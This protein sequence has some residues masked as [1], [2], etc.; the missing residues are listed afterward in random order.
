MAAPPRNRITLPDPLRWVIG[1][2]AALAV[3]ATGYVIG[4]AT[5]IPFSTAWWKDFARPLATVGAGVFAGDPL[6]VH[7]VGLA[8]RDEPHVECCGRL[9]LRPTGSIEDGA[10]PRGAADWSVINMPGHTDDA[11]RRRTACS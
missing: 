10:P 11:N 6:G 7:H 5:E 8:I 4:R 3:L 1:I 9:D 2:L